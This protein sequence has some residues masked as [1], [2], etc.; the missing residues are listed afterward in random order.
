MFTHRLAVI[1]GAL[2]GGRLC[3]Y[4]TKDCSTQSGCGIRTKRIRQGFSDVRTLAE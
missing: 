4:R 2:D 3:H 1:V